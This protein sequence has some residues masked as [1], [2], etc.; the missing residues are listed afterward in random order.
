MA[1]AAFGEVRDD[2]LGGAVAAQRRMGRR[3]IGGQENVTRTAGREQRCA[4]EVAETHVP[5][6]RDAGGPARQRTGQ[7]RVH[8]IDFG[9]REARLVACRL[10]SPVVRGMH[11]AGSVGRDDDTR[12][13]AADLQAATPSARRRKTRLV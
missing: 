12:V 1:R 3:V 11:D 10:L 5:G 13:Y 8:V 9:G 6:A 2:P 7:Q 4:P